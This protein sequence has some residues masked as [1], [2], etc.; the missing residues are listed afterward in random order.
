[1]LLA[2]GVPHPV[3]T[4]VWVGTLICMWTACLLNARRCKRRHCVWNGPFF[5]VNTLRSLSKGQHHFP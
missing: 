1:M 3:K 5:P 4:W 2:I